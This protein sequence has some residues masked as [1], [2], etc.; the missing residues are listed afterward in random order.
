MVGQ[1][2][3]EYLKKSVYWTCIEHSMK[4]AGYYMP[5]N[6][7]NFVLSASLRP[8]VED[9]SIALE[10]FGGRR[11]SS[12]VLYAPKVAEADTIVRRAHESIIHHVDRQM[13]GR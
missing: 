13:R 4:S 5:I 8:G 10:T 2:L 6:A 11:S 3:I 7:A 1:E 9:Y 12:S